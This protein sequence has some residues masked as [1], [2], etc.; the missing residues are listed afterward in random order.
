MVVATGK[1]CN[2]CG[3]AEG[4]MAWMGNTCPDCMNKEMDELYEKIGFKKNDEGEWYNPQK[5]T[6]GFVKDP[7]D[8]REEIK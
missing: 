5:V 2:K 1:V 4:C 8:I 6:G 7:V 3:R